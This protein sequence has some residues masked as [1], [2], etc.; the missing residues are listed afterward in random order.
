MPPNPKPT[1]LPKWATSETPVPTWAISTVYALDAVVRNGTNIY[2]CVVAGT[3]ASSGGGPT[4]T[5]S[6]I[7]DGVG[8]L[9]W[10]YTG[11]VTS[12]SNVEPSGWKKIT[13]WL[14]GESPPANIANWVLN[15]IYTWCQYIDTLFDNAITWTAAHIFSSTVQVNGHATFNGNIIAGG[16]IQLAGD[17][18]FPSAKTEEF[19]IAASNFSGTAGAT[20]NVPAAGG[21]PYL[22]N[23]T[24]SGQNPVLTAQFFAT[25]GATITG[26]QIL[27]DATG[28]TGPGSARIDQI[29]LVAQDAGSALTPWTETRTFVSNAQSIWGVGD[30]QQWRNITLT[31]PSDATVPTSGIVTI[32]LRIPAP[33]ETSEQ[34]Q[35]YAARLI[36]TR[37]SARLP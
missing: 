12:Q 13:G 32:R 14:Y 18:T 23:S 36:T 1:K 33:T 5:G 10:A 35:F 25:P 3:S 21:A 15:N 27:G 37:T 7:V 11:V 24:G 29:Y 19:I 22:S 30:V 20:M 26:L 8:T 31:P 28:G 4:G 16:N 17:L 2:T 6:L 9:R 34:M